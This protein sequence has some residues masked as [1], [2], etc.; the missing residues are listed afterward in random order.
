MSQQHSRMFD[1]IIRAPEMA[2]KMGR[3][4]KTLREMEKRGDIPARIAGPSGRPLGWLHSDV[5]AL[6]RHKN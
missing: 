1:R 4:V 3:A 5:E 6:F 2:R